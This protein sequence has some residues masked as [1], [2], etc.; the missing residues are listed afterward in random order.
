MAKN[1]LIVESPAKTKTLAR[2]LG[3]DFDIMATV[4]HIIDLPKSKIGVDPDNNF[5]IQYETISGKEKVITALKKAAK[6]AETIY[7]APDPDRE[8]E[9]IAWHVE[10]TLKK[11]TKAEFVRVSFNEITKSAV[12]KAIESP[13]K[14]N[15]NLVNSQQARRA[16]DRI[17]G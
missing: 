6:K 17:F 4:G 14:I 10:K 11:N 9:A 12:L 2:F 5:E 1:L 7:L 3:A 8:G 13:T 15:M 16:L